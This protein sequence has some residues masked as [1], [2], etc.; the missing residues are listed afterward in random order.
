MSM[1]HIPTWGKGQLCLSIFNTDFSSP[2]ARGK[3]TRPMAAARPAIRKPVQ[4]DLPCLEL[5][6]PA[7]P[8]VKEI[9]RPEPVAP[10]P[11]LVNRFLTDELNLPALVEDI[12]HVMA[13]VAVSSRWATEWTALHRWIE[14]AS[15]DEGGAG[16]W[17]EAGGLY[18][19][20]FLPAFWE[21]I[22]AQRAEP[23]QDLRTVKAY[24]ESLGEIWPVYRRLTI[25]KNVFMWWPSEELEESERRDVVGCVNQQRAMWRFIKGTGR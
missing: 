22:E 8:A 16:F 17:C 7:F 2:L 11:V 20:D 14:A 23:D 1:N 15:M 25:E 24:G 13:A 10:V 6:P 3:A 19:A 12:F 5:F 4:Q 9:K 18:P 21:G